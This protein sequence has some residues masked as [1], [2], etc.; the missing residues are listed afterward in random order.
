MPH[1]H[2]DNLKVS[3]DAPDEVIRAAFRALATKYHP[4][5]NLGN[6]RAARVMG[7][8]NKSYEV[9]SDPQ[10]RQEY[11]RKL[12][13][14]GPRSEEFSAKGPEPKPRS[15]ETAQT[16]SSRDAKT[17]SDDSARPFVVAAAVIALLIVWMM[18]SVGKSVPVAVTGEKP[19]V[20]VSPASAA[21]SREVWR[22]VRPLVAPDS[23]PWSDVSRYIGKPSRHAGSCEVAIDNSQND[24]DKMVKLFD[25]RTERPVA[26]FTFFLRAHDHFTVKSIGPGTYDI[27]SQDLDSGVISKSEPF[28]LD[29]SVEETTQ[30]DDSVK[31]TTHYSKY[32][33][34][35]Y[36]VV[37]GN[38]K[39][40]IIAPEEFW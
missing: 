15:P 29:E 19:K 39:F 36:T 27:R 3:R 38:T 20:P 40:S 17:S 18:I 37:D 4:D 32:S 23:K 8:I 9:L 6:E 10:K 13:N 21:A 34:T 22:Y 12:R 1:T 7:I 11:D 24:S 25:R 14:D 26:V 28:S 31:R 33:L 5:L 2:Y 30:P 16:T 35:L